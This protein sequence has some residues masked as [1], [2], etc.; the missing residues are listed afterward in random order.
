MDLGQSWTY[1]LWVGVAVFLIV[2]QFRPKPISEKTLVMLPLIGGLIGLQALARTPPD[3]LA[4]VTLISVNL[5]LGA[6]LGLA[7]GASSKV[8]RTSAGTWVSRGG[9]LTLV[10]WL[11]A[12]GARIGLAVSFPGALPLSELPLF[13][14]VTFGAQNLVL[15]LRTEGRDG[16]AVQ[17]G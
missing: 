9:V 6:V 8:W 1:L 4:A 17:A 11:A 14:A 5:A 3:S 10:L 15:W 13:L 2:R 12:V 16:S 7:R